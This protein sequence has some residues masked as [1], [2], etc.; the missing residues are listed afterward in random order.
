MT[1][2]QRLTRPLAL[3]LGA[4]LAA[5][6]LVATVQAPASAAWKTSTSIDGG[7]LQVCKRYVRGQNYVRFRLDNRRA[8]HTHLGGLS[9]TRNGDTR[10]FSVRAAAGRVSRVVQVPVRPSDSLSTG[11]GEVTGEGGGGGT[12]PLS[13]FPR[14]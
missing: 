13:T 2:L 1:A 4:L 9:R 8:D 7:K 14:C 10:S 3:L 6:T 11:V 5:V 12:G